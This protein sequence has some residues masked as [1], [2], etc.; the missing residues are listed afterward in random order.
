MSEGASTWA[1]QTDAEE[2]A[3]VAAERQVYCA[4]SMSSMLSDVLLMYYRLGFDL[5]FTI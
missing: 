5:H 2:R 1:E 4:M 3:T